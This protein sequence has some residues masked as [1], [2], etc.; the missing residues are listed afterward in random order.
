MSNPNAPVIIKKVIEEGGHGHHGGAWKVAYADFVTAMMAFFLMLWLLSTSSDEKLAGLAEFFSEDG[1]SSGEPG[2]VGGLLSG[3]SPVFDDISVNAPVSPFAMPMALPPSDV[4]DDSDNFAID[5][6]SGEIESEEELAEALEAERQALEQEQFEEA[7]AQIIQAL[8]SSPELNEYADSLRID[9]TEDGLRIQLIDGAGYAMFPAGQSAMF[10]HTQKLIEVV[11]KTIQGLPNKLS[12][13]G[14]TDSTPFAA[15]SG[16]DNWTLS[17]DRANATRRALIAG[18]ISSDRVAEVI[19]KADS[20]HLFEEAPRDPRNRRI[21]LVLL[22]EPKPA[23]NAI[24]RAVTD[25]F[26]Q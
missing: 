23:V 25:P 18:G 6:L 22:K 9:N 13:R 16:Q 20:Q 2:G 7:K 17:A 21:S 14:H 4:E 8:N 24:D 12:I 1:T 11:A 3:T 10:E 5:L 26:G 19:G 15:G